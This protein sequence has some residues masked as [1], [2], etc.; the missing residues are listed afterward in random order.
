MTTDKTS[1]DAQIE[2]LIQ[3]ESHVH[4]G[5]PPPPGVQPFVIIGR[6]SSVMISAPHGTRTYRNSDDEKWHEEDEFTA[7]MALLLAERCGVSA[8]ANVWR[9]DA[10]DPNYHGECQYKESLKRIVLGKN[11][12]FVLDLHGARQDNE[13]L[14]NALVDLG[15]RKDKQ[16][17]EAKHRDTFETQLRACFGEEAVSFDRFA[18]SK[19][20]TVTGYCQSTL[21][22]QA[23]Q[24]EMKPSVRVP[25]RRTDASA[26]AKLGAY[27][28]PPGDVWKMLGVLADFIRYLKSQ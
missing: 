14:G 2:R 22:I 25:V 13:K 1:V 5:E 28:A 11:V 27:S 16:S 7:G 6:D 10:H 21:G 19:P 23:V 20:E 17:L 9:D 15:T 18:A 26:F 24:I 12:R 4:Y 3:I 8:I